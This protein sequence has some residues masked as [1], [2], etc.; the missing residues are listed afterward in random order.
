MKLDAHNVNS[1]TSK[2][3]AEMPSWLNEACEYS[4]TAARQSIHFLSSIFRINELVKQMPYNGYF[5]SSSAFTLIYD[6]MHDPSS[7]PSHLR[8]VYAA[9]HNLSTMKREE[10]TTSTISAIQTTLRNIDPSYEW[11]PNPNSAKE[12]VQT[13]AF[14]IMLPEPRAPSQE[15]PIQEDLAIPTNYRLGP[16]PDPRTSQW[17]YPAPEGPETGRSGG[18]SDDLPDFTQ[19][20]MG[21]DFDFSTMDLEAFFSVYPSSASTFPFGNMSG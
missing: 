7:A 18:S 11:S 4:L 3:P 10:P 16:R 12:P 19:S 20:E 5:M 9:L 15:Q 2:R 21:W 13:G 14:Q 6:F 17:S 1:R 8:W